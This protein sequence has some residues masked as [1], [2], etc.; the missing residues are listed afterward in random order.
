MKQYDFQV[1]TVKNKNTSAIRSLICFT[2]NTRTGFKHVAFLEGSEHQA[3][4]C[5]YSNRTWESYRYKTVID[6]LLSEN[7]GYE[8]VRGL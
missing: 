6:K 4:K 5:F 1:F 3:V 8:L 2:E 7:T